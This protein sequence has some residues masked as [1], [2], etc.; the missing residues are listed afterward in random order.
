VNSINL[1]AAA[2]YQVAALRDYVTRSMSVRQNN[3]SIEV[4]VERV[5]VICQFTL[6]GGDEA[7]QNASSRMHLF[8]LNQL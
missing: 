2:I 5:Q 8:L 7:F 1:P 6:A 3:C 4:I